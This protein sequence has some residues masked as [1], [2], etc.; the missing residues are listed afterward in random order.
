MQRSIKII[1]NDNKFIY[2]ILNQSSMAD[3]KVVIFVHGFTGDSNE[4]QF[5]NAAPFFNTKGFATFR[6]NFY[7]REPDAR[8]TSNVSFSD[9]LN[10]T[11]AVIDHLSPQFDEIYLVGHSLGACVVSLVNKAN[12]KRI[13]LWDPANGFSSPQ[14]KGMVFN[15]ALNGYVC[16][17]KMEIIFGK[18]LIEDWMDI[19]VEKQI[20]S[21]G[22]PTKIIFAR[23]ENKYNEWKDHLSSITV[24]NS[25]AILDGASHQF[26][27]EGKS[28]E[29]FE[30]TY[31]W[32]I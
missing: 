4:H 26:V 27:E 9:H 21:F 18:E 30:E 22:V 11:R 15:S 3:S 1:T 8:K 5:I 20:K 17:Y 19:T 13:V 29:L 25:H 32:F 24:E 31:K 14:E 12:V 23:N 16:D 7:G 10:D 2:G 6:F 28:T